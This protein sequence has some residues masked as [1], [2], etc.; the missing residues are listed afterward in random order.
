MRIGIP[1]FGDQVAP[2]FE[3]TQDVLLVEIDG[4]VATER[5]VALY[6]EAEEKNLPA[7]CLSLGVD[8]L[9]C[10]GITPW[11][12]QTLGEK[13]V[14]VIAGVMGSSDQALE[15]FREGTLVAGQ[16]LAAG[17]ARRDGNRSGTKR[18]TVTAE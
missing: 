16:I 12:E 9:V 10:C 3:T 2:R 7:A 4:E 13:G 5:H 15:R 1:V 11:C 6:V 18:R 14:R 8:V 17:A